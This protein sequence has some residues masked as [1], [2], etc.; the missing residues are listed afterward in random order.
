MLQGCLAEPFFF[1][2]SVSSN[3]NS[4]QK[5]GSVEKMSNFPALKQKYLYK[6]SE[7]NEPSQP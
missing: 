7:P 2:F 5:R 1:F 4:L 3:L 6:T